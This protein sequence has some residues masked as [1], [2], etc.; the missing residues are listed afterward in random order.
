[1][2]AKEK[3]ERLKRVR[4]GRGLQETA[5]SRHNR[6]DTHKLTETVT[7]YTRPAEV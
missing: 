6:T 2:C 4:G 5:S 1:M 7:V 3:A